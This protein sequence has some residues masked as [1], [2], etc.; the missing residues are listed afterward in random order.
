MTLEPAQ[1]P[2]GLQ[3]DVLD[4]GST[5]AGEPDDL[6]SIQVPQSTNSVHVSRL[7]AALQAGRSTVTD[8]AD[9]LCCKLVQ[10]M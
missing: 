1:V 10:S 5:R 9:Y 6:A 4:H 8:I 2:V 3:P 7:Q